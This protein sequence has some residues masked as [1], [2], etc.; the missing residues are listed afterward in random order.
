MTIGFP[1]LNIDKIYEF[2]GKEFLENESKEFKCER[3][4]KIFNWVYDIGITIDLS[5]YEKAFKK[6]KRN[7][8]DEEKKKFDE[9][10]KTIREE[11][12]KLAK[13]TAEKIR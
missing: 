12:Y 7:M 10:R 9:E 1:V 6:K 11:L 5:K 13:K 4:K 3:K 2:S 8:T